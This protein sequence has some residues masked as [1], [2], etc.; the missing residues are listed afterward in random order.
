MEQGNT[1]YMYI[2]NV[3]HSVVKG[4]DASN[5]FTDISQNNYQWEG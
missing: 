2:K 1:K 5:E 4:S 3:G